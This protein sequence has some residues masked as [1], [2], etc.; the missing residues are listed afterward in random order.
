MHA[1]SIISE[2]VRKQRRWGGE[3]GKS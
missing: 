1:R 2:K 3:G